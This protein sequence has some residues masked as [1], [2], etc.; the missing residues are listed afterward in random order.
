MKEK[1]MMKNIVGFLQS[2][3]IFMKQEFGNAVG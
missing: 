1:V 2:S 3:I